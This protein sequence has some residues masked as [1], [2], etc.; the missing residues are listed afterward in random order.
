MSS[1][2]PAWYVGDA[3]FAAEQRLIWGSSWVSVARTEDVAEIGSFVSGSIAGDPFVVVR[4][5]EGRLRALAN[6][7]PHR[8]SIIAEGAGTAPALRCPYHG[9]TFRLDGKLAAAPQMPGLD[10]AEHC[11]PQLGVDVWNGWVFV[12]LDPDAPPVAT[13]LSALDEL[14]EP[15]DLAQMQRVGRLE[16]EVNVNWKLI[17]ENFAESYHHAA[18]HPETLHR[19]FPGHKSWVLDNE[20]EPWMWLD[21]ESTSDEF[22]PFA[23]VLAF[24]SHMFSIL[25]GIG[26]DWIRL[27]A[28]SP[29]TTRLVSELF[30]PPHL[31]SNTGLIEVLMHAMT[32]VN[33][34]DAACVERVHAGLLSRWARPGPVSPLEKGCIQFRSWL[35]DRLAEPA[36]GAPVEL[37]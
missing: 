35:V 26:L 36:I 16:S 4:D 13:Q 8:G 18:V 1:L 32:E 24:P 22:E 2:P 3:N 15:F 27:E 21:H 37:G 34:E 6:V 14:V 5:K 11:L 17:V 33:D 9:W 19:D 25:R 28:T 31:A 12:N 20:G 23:V 10:L 7:C 30:L 29:T